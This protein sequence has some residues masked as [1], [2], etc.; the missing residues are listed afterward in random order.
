M[1]KIY[2]KDDLNYNDYNIA[3]EVYNLLKTK[4]PDYVIGYEERYICGRISP[5]IEKIIKKYRDIEKEE[6][7]KHIFNFILR[8]KGIVDNCVNK[9]IDEFCNEQDKLYLLEP[10]TFEESFIGKLN[11]EIIEEMKGTNLYYPDVFSSKLEKHSPGI[12][13]FTNKIYKIYKN[14]LNYDFILSQYSWKKMFIYNKNR[15]LI[16][17]SHDHDTIEDAFY[18]GGFVIF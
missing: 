17:Y 18:E 12:N 16:L 6:E 3:I 11:K 5:I 7:K 1:K 13:G 10:F 9:C 14:E 15:Q 2:D 8:K 4:I